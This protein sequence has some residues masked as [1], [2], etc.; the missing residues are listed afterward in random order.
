MEQKKKYGQFFTTNYKEILQDLIIPSD[1]KVIIEPF[2][3]QGDLLPFIIENTNNI[4][5]EIYDIKNNYNNLQKEKKGITINPFI[6]QDTLKNPPN[7][8]NT[9][10]ITNPPYLARNKSTNKSIYDKYKTND[11][12]KCFLLSLI[13]NP[14]NGGIIILPL[15]FFCNMRKNDIDLRNDF[16]QTFDIINLNIFE[17]QVFQDTSYQICSFSFK[18]NLNKIK[19]KIIINNIFFR[20]KK[21]KLLNDIS[22]FKKDKWLIGGEIFSL[23]LNTN[24]S[25]YRY[26]KNRNYDHLK[27]QIFYIETIDTKSNKIN[28]TLNKDIFYGKESSRTTASI[29]T[30]ISN[31]NINDQKEICKIF[32]NI[33]NNYRNKYNSLFL[34]NF[35]DNNRKK[36]S[37]TL[38]YDLLNHSIL[39]WI[40]NNDYLL[41][42]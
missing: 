23:K 1:I 26:V 19:Q 18:L 29:N 31:L 16:F 17:K 40:E 11:L 8:E 33:L 27:K 42:N 32:N 35:R 14:P 5:I 38:V 9:F 6:K 30:S 3:G 36:I 10:V 12:F 24:I 15:N 37:F 28:L 25:I 4:K 34:T 7:Y 39:K 13:K 22:I 2:V 41:I 20:N 21:T